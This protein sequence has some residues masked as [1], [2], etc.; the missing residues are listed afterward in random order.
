MKSLGV[1]LHVRLRCFRLEWF[2][3]ND[4]SSLSPTGSEEF[5]TPRFCGQR[6]VRGYGSVAVSL[7]LAGN[8]PHHVDPGGRRQTQLSR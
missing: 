5:V 8:F 4:E 7:L 6:G 2:H 1:G 3:E